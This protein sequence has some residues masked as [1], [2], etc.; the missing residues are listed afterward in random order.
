MSADMEATG[1]HK[2]DPNYAIICSFIEH[3]AKLFYDESVSISIQDLDSFLKAESGKEEVNF[4]NETF[5]VAV[6]VIY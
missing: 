4:C 3:F 5:M 1:D 2:L 6:N